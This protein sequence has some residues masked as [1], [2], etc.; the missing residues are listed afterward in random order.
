MNSP[1]PTRETTPPD[2][3]RV[4]LRILPT[5]SRVHRVLSSRPQPLVIREETPIETQRWRWRRIYVFGKNYILKRVTNSSA[6]LRITRADP[7]NKLTWFF[8][9]T[10]GVLLA[11]EKGNNQ[12]PWL[13]LWKNWEMRKDTSLS[14]QTPKKTA[15]ITDETATSSALSK[16]EPRIL[17]TVAAASLIVCG[18]ITYTVFTWGERHDDS[19]QAE[20]HE[21]TGTTDRS[22][23]FNIPPDSEAFFHGPDDLNPIITTDTPV[24]W[25]TSSWPVSPDPHQIE[26]NLTESRPGF[27][28][29]I[30][31]RITTILNIWAQFLNSRLADKTISTES[32]RPHKNPFV[33]QGLQVT[34]REE[35][36][37]I[38]TTPEKRTRNIINAMD[39]GQDT[40]TLTGRWQI[41]KQ[42]EYLWGEIGKDRWIALANLKDGDINVAELSPDVWEKIQGEYAIWQATWVGWLFAN[43]LFDGNSSIIADISPSWDV[44]WEVPETPISPTETTASESKNWIMNMLDSGATLYPGIE[45]IEMR[46]GVMY[47]QLTLGDESGWQESGEIP[48]YDFNGK[49]ALLTTEQMKRLGM[50]LEALKTFEMSGLP[51]STEIIIDRIFGLQDTPTWTANDWDLLPENDPG[52]SEPSAELLWDGNVDEEWIDFFSDNSW[53]YPLPVIQLDLL[54]GKMLVAKEKIRVYRSPDNASYT[55]EQRTLEA[56]ETFLVGRNTYEGLTGLFVEIIQAGKITWWAQIARQLP[57]QWQRT[58]LVSPS[59]E[60]TSSVPSTEI[61]P[62]DAGDDDPFREIAAVGGTSESE[63]ETPT[64]SEALT[65]SPSSLI[66]PEYAKQL[67][68]WVETTNQFLQDDG[69]GEKTKEFQTQRVITSGSEVFEE[70]QDPNSDTC[71]IRVINGRDAWVDVSGNK[72]YIV[73]KGKNGRLEPTGQMYCPTGDDSVPANKRLSISTEEKW[74]LFPDVEQ[75]ILDGNIPH[76][77]FDAS[78][79]EDP[80]LIWLEEMNGR[81]IKVSGADGRDYRVILRQENGQVRIAGLCPEDDIP[82]EKPSRSINTAI[83]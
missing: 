55:K 1:C 26:A 2:Q 7:S 64:I 18:W 51:D 58:W 69:N 17:N 14:R 10:K 36:L 23:E 80:R 33:A 22:P 28:A 5:H 52:Y 46:S 27:M 54:R 63:P 78:S 12:A 3:R 49:W 57:S 39:G 40:E 59:R 70:L 75:D 38:R 13:M 65:R 32:E 42:G 24:I 16:W 30:W 68:E 67:Q 43:T 15:P 83:A 73:M 56:G 41:D 79:L 45:W 53:E 20:R 19:A 47:L 77:F 35:T 72:T 76:V 48:L 4:T 11:R 34:S 21:N 6:I 8:D 50:S 71:Y 61:I 25:S 62:S 29:G 44:S 37:Y 60:T 82:A 74:Q 31:N 81:N 66:M 9:R